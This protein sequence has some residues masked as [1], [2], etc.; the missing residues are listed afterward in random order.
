MRRHGG[1]PIDTLHCLRENRLSPSGPSMMTC[2]R[3]KSCEGLRY[4]IFACPVG[5]RV[6]NRF[7][8][9]KQGVRTLS[10]PMTL[11]GVPTGS[12]TPVTGV[13]GRCPRPLDDGDVCCASI[14]KSG[15]QMQARV[16]RKGRPYIMGTRGCQAAKPK[17][18]ESGREH[19]QSNTTGS[20][21]IA[22][23]AFQASAAVS[24]WVSF[25][26]AICRRLSAVRMIS[27]ARSPSAIPVF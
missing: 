25:R 22:S 7:T 9:K 1:L 6:G 11:F 3:G 16:S 18:G 8:D 2:S 21:R 14:Q 17:L 19:G 23:R 4:K 24:G 26:E 5:N 12:R 20:R 15:S 10:N 27:I 13:K